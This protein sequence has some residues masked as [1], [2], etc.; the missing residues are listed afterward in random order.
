MQVCLDALSG[1]AGASSSP[2]DETIGVEVVGV[3]LP[4]G[5]SVGMQTENVDSIDL[6]D[7]R[8]SWTVDVNR[9]SSSARKR[10]DWSR[11]RRRCASMLEH[12]ASWLGGL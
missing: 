7:V 6:L 11:S 10:T 5:D 4:R 3:S 1:H 9:V 8:V 12:F 2:C